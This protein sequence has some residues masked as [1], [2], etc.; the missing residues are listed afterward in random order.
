MYWHNVLKNIAKSDS[1]ED[2]S[3]QEY[4]M[5]DNYIVKWEIINIGVML[6]CFTEWKNETKKINLQR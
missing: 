5:C 3:W 2:F 4:V 1:L 6:W